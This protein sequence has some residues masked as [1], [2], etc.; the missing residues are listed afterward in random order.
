MAISHFDYVKAQVPDYLHSVCQGVIKLFIGLWT[1]S[2]NSTE[3][4]YLDDQKRSLLN[5]RL[6]EMRPPYEVT[7]TSRPIEDI[8]KWKASEFRAFALYYFPALEGLL[9][10]DFYQHFLYLV[11][12]LQVL[13][14]ENVSLK[15]VKE[16]DLVFR[17]FVKQAAV[18]YGEKHMRF[19]M[20]LLTH[21]SQSV[22]NWGCLWATSTFI[23]EW[24][25]GQLVALINGT[26]CVAEQ[27]V[28]SF[29]LRNVIRAEAV[30]I[31]SR[32]ILPRNVVTLLQDLLNIPVHVD[33]EEEGCFQV[34][35]CGI[36]LLGRPKKRKTNLDYEIAFSNY[37]KNTSFDIEGMETHHSYKRLLLPRIQG[38]FATT[39][40]IRSPKRVNDC[41]FMKNGKFFIIESILHFPSLS[42]DSQPFVIGR[43]MGT[44]SCVPCSPPPLSGIV[45]DKLA[46]Q[47]TWVIGLSKSLIVYSANDIFKKCVLVL[48][49]SAHIHSYIVTALPNSV[50]SD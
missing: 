32:F 40:Y 21:L 9:P 20:H 2:K 14:Q 13:L 12:G 43:S 8:A 7:R 5:Q 38:F 45:F 16:T 17:H 48:K 34:T 46:G 27:M 50:E 15:L 28:N 18:L 36:K 3:P 23:P 10:K 22:V 35:P 31:L 39:S 4:W 47:S 33:E 6:L 11:Y 49:P 1:D 29:R 30:S 42:I 25:N 26:Q 44:I 41:A 19:N 24:F 37:F